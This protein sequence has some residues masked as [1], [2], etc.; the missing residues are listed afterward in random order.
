MGPEMPEAHREGGG[1]GVGVGRGK[2]GADQ[3][4]P[5]EQRVKEREDHDRPWSQRSDHIVF[6]SR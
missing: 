5:G 2:H 1:G 4:E 6:Y 3:S